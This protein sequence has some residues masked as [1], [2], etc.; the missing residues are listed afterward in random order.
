M[1]WLLFFEHINGV[2]KNIKFTQEEGVQESK[3]AFLDCCVKIEVSGSLS[4]TV[5]RKSTHTDQYLMFDSHHPLIYKLGLIRTLFHRANNIPST[6]ESKSRERE[7]LKSTLCDYQNWTFERALK[8][9][10]KPVTTSS[11]SSAIASKRRN[12]FTIPYVAGVS[13]KLKRIFGKHQNPPGI[14]KA[15]SF[16]PSC[17]KILSA[18]S[19]IFGKQNNLCTSVCINTEDPAFLVLMTQQFILTSKQQITLLRTRM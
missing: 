1:S 9:R 6:E 17:A 11:T 5:Y 7:H 2:D 4:T 16:M 3:L 8:P 18:R 19:S 14:S 12:N 15:I 10:E 13:E